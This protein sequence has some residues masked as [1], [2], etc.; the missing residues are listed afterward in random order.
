MNQKVSVIIPAYN[1]EQYLDE[2]IQSIINQDYHEI[3]VL[4][5]DDGS[6]DQTLQKARKWEKND[7]RIMVIAQDN[8]GAPAARN[9]GLSRSDGTYVLFF[10]ADDVMAEGAIRVMVDG[11][12]DD[13]DICITSF[14]VNGRKNT[15]NKVSGDFKSFPEDYCLLAPYPGTKLYKLEVIHEN[16]LLFGKLK[17]AQDLNFYLKY[18]CFARNAVFIDKITAYY[19][20]VDNSI[21]HVL[22]TRVIDILKS[23]DEA[24]SIAENTRNAAMTGCMPIIRMININSQLSKFRGA[25]HSA[26]T[27]RMYKALNRAYKQSKKETVFLRL[28]PVCKKKYVR[29]IL[30]MIRI[31]HSY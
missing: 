11:M 7:S 10:D 21:S 12:H 31:R 14:S 13:V 22:D 4:I 3:Q 5:V 26:D 30:S 24:D 1:A 17:V 23:I 18:L 8:A 19:R 15:V 9:H 25:T 16:H 29:S 27:D 20:V 2:C 28:S 6:T